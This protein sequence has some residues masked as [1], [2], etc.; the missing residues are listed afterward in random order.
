[1]SKLILRGGLGRMLVAMALAVAAAGAMAQTA[2]PVGTW[3][4]I[5]DRSGQPKALIQ[6]MQD[7][8]GTLSGKVLKGLGA[9]FQTGQRCTA[10]KGSR[11][12]QLIIGMTILTGM[13]QEGNKADTKWAG[14]QIVDPESGSIYHC[15]MHLTDNGRKL[16]VRGFIGM[17]LLGRSQTWL[18]Q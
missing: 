2:S 9:E 6:I 16:V 12:D 14:G 5:D 11:K 8:A 17:P 7:G 3:Q 10:C 15:E 1:M 18:R 4:T 13:K